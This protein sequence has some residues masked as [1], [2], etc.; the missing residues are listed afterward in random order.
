M[1]RR[2]RTKEFQRHHAVRRTAG[3]GGT[4][5][6][7]DELLAAPPA[8]WRRNC[9]AWSKTRRGCRMS[10]QRAAAIARRR[11]AFSGLACLGRPPVCAQKAAGPAKKAAAR[12]AEL[13]E[14]LDRYNYRYH[15]LDDPEVPDAEYDRLMLELRALETQHP[16]LLS[17]GFAHATRGCGS[18]RR[19][20]HREAPA[21]HAVPGQCVQRGGSARLRSP[22]SG[23][24]RAAGTGPLFG[25][26]EIGRLGH[27][28][29]L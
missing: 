5:D 16:E 6:T 9:P 25:G 19:V 14:L 18:G 13:K 1:L 27:Q 17:A 22:H 2:W 11:C 26:T 29:A 23:T 8:A 3:A 20:R 28:R 10:P 12:V 4:A 21:R 15:A 7:V 24:S